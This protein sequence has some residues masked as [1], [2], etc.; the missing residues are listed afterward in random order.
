MLKNPSLAVSASIISGIVA[1]TGDM[2]VAGEQRLLGETKVWKRIEVSRKTPT[3]FKIARNTMEVVANKSVA[4]L[5]RELK[6]VMTARPMVEWQWR[7]TKNI[8][9]TDQ[10]IARAD[11]RPVA[12]HLWFDDK[13]GKSLFGSVASLLGRPRVGHLLTYVWGGKRAPGAVLPNPYYPKKGAI[14]IL[15]NAKSNTKGWRT[16]KRDIVDDF[17]RSFG[18]SPNLATLRYVSVSGDTDDTR[19]YSK[20]QIRAFKITE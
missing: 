7:V 15:R 17:R 2:A 12:V 3:E 8:P 16:E 19:T 14:I 5:Y 10:G 1:L 18:K 13:S 9:A 11:D 4:F 6:P 20:S